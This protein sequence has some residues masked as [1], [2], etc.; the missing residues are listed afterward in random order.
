[1]VILNFMPLKELQQDWKKNICV[2][3][4][5]YENGLIYPVHGFIIQIVWIYC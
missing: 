4:F 2:N 3:V 5:G 1:M